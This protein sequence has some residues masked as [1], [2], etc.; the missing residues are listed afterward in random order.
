M[1][2]SRLSHSISIMTTIVFVILGLACATVETSTSPQPTNQNISKDTKETIEIDWSDESSSSVLPEIMDTI[3]SY[4]RRYRYYDI[5]Y[6]T[7]INSTTGSF[8]NKIEFITWSSTPYTNMTLFFN[9][10]IISYTF[11]DSQLSSSNGSLFRESP[12]STGSSVYIYTR[13][14]NEILSRASLA[15]KGLTV[16]NS[17]KRDYDILWLEALRFRD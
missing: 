13:Y 11:T 14:V 7:N 1:K 15:L 8:F 17:K 16:G 9:Y 4:L 6:F 12:Y 3:Q 2:G 10:V 5:E